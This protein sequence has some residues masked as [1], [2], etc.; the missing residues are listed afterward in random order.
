VFALSESLNTRV[1]R[2]IYLRYVIRITY[3]KIVK[4]EQMKLKYF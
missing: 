4:T 3:R 1:Q 2:S